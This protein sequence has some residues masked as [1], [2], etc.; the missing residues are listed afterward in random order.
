MSERRVRLGEIT[1]PSGSVFLF[2]FGYMNLWCHNRPV[3]FP[4]GVMSAE[5]TRNANAAADYRIDGPDA[6]TAGRTWDR[7]WHPR[8]VYDLPAHGID[9]IEKGFAEHCRA[10]NLRA[11]LTRL[12]ERVP[13]RTRATQALEHGSGAGITFLSGM[14]VVVVSG[15]PTDH[16]LPVFASRM[17]GSDTAVCDRWEWVDL[18]V[19][20]RSQVAR[21]EEIGPVTV[22]KARLFFADL[23]AVGAWEHEQPLDG[24]ADFLIWGRD[25]SLASRTLNVPKLDDVTFGWLDGD[26]HDLAQKGMKVE[27]EQEKR[28]WVMGTD[29]RPHSHHYHLMKP[30]RESPTDSGCTEVG[31]ATVC[32][33]MTSWGDGFF[34]VFRELNAAGELVRVRIRLGDERRVELIHKMY[35]KHS[36]P[37]PGD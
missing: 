33:F 7:Q 35:A 10:H 6:E 34:P 24:Q 31:G 28:G 1:C 37:S 11:E 18:D 9:Q 36:A 20:P 4:D 12:P 19:R 26:V 30:I 25:A 21:S 13:H 27:A 15:L 16:P 29:F 23:D 17:G 2:D 5:A 8:Y 3:V 32:G 14:H 22:D